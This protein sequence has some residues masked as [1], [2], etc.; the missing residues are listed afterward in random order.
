MH[1]M[2][3]SAIDMNLLVVLDALLRERHVG[4]AATAIGRSQPAVSHALSRL[5]HLF[6]DPLL[7]R[8]GR[9]M[10]ATPRAEELREPLSR[11]LG[12]VSELFEPA[13]F[14]PASSRRAFRL[15]MPDVIAD[16][17]VPRLVEHLAIDA[18]GV[19]LEIASWRGINTLTPEYLER[20]DLL[21]SIWTGRFAGFR[22]E[23]LFDDTDVL[24]MRAARR[25]AARLKRLAGFLAAP[26]V[27][28]VGP[29]ENEDPVDTWLHSRGHARI[30]ALAVP[31]YLLALRIVARTDLVA[32]LPSR[33]VASMGAAVPV[34]AIALPLRPGAD[35]IH[36]HYPTKAEVDPA[37]VWLR[38]LVRLS[39]RSR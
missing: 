38:R 16:E 8:A 20:I 1:A 7:A 36:L 4:R 10:V 32:V 28:V 19:R 3:L 22:H 12:G 14:D 30:V 34:K 17:L 23:R 2:K 9:R 29:G 33:L 13:T 27:A 24:T 6:G 31:S 35:D 39:A 21:V 37:A 5:R 15:M 11:A 18:P 25:D 26:Q